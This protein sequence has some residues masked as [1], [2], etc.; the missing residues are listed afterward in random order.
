MGILSVF[1][2]SYA[3]WELPLRWRFF[4]ASDRGSLVLSIAKR[5]PF[6]PNISIDDERLPDD[7]P[8]PNEE[9]PAKWQAIIALESKMRTWG[10]A[11][12]NL[13]G[14]AYIPQL[15]MMAVPWPV[16]S[17]LFGAPSVFLILRARRRYRRFAN[18]LCLTCGYDLR[19]SPERC[20]ECGTARAAEVSLRG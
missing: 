12:E 7:A 8:N 6:Q 16:L 18:N 3:G 15:R 1:H 13:D 17:L 5:F 9:W 14:I 2:T 10:F 20:P 4:A 11:F 19:H